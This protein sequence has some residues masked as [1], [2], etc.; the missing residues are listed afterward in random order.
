MKCIVIGLGNFGV[1]L[2]QRLTMRGNEVLA[3]DSDLEKVNKYK[4][5]IS[6]TVALDVTNEMALRTLPLKEVDVVFVV[7]GKEFGTS[8]LVIALLKQIGVKRIV[9]RSI[10]AVHSVILKSMGITELINPEKE[11]ADFFATK[12]EL[13]TTIDSYIV[14]DDHL[15]VEWELHPDFVGRKLVDVAFKDNFD[16][17][18]IALKRYDK[19][20]GKP[21]VI[22]DVPND[23]VLEKGDILVLYGTLRSFRQLGMQFT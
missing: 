23:I 2:S 22:Q 10:S 17:Q 6:S 14:D 8:L 16:L 3:V 11:Y 21:L 19:K 1:A 12:V 9:A 7:L 18:L 4:D 5:S 15:V 20:A 13:G